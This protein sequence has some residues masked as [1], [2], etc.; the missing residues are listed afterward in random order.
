MAKNKIKKLDLVLI[1]LFYNHKKKVSIK[2]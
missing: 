1:M 2:E